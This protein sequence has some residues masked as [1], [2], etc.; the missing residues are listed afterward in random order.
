[1]CVRANTRLPPSHRPPAQVD[2]SLFD[3]GN[4]AP[5]NPSPV[6]VRRSYKNFQRRYEKC[7]SMLTNGQAVLP[8]LD[9]VSRCKA[10]Y[11][12]GAYVHQYSEH[13][14][15][16]EEFEQSFLAVDQVMNSYSRLSAS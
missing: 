6:A 9:R 1:M 4:F 5:F 3:T 13:G 2:C 15:G 8:L 7:G 16:K 11:D 12:V 14:V 10:K